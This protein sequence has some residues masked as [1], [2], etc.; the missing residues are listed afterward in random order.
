MAKSI[1]VAELL[2]A[3]ECYR[4]ARL[5][6]VGFENCDRVGGVDLST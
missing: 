3:K 4:K 1:I 5:E 6:I 2:I